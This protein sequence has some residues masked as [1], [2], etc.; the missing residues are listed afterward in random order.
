MNL[1]PLKA[2]R[3]NLLG[4]EMGRGL[5]PCYLTCAPENTGYPAMAYDKAKFHYDGDFPKDLAPENGGTH[6]GMFLAWAIHRGLASE[7]LIEDA[8]GE[9]DAVRD[10]RKTGR[11]LLFTYLDQGIG[12]DDLNDE[13]NAFAESY[14]ASNTFLKDY[15]KL[16][17]NRYPT[18]YHVEDTWENFDLVADMI[19]KRYAKWKAKHGGPAAG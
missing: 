5:L 10:R 11:E 7:E 13:G 8:A 17:T 14:Y 3:D 1:L 18:C 16:F 6:I 19:D 2:S 4:L 15:E 9:I 12:E